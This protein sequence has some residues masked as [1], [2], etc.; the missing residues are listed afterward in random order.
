MSH[1]LDRA[2]SSP[3]CHSAIQGWYLSLWPVVHLWERWLKLRC[4]LC[5]S[6]TTLLGRDPHI[7]KKV[8]WY[9]FFPWAGAAE[10][11]T[12]LLYL[13]LWQTPTYLES[14]KVL[15]VSSHWVE[16]AGRERGTQGTHT[17][18]VSLK[19]FSGHQQL[20]PQSWRKVEQGAG[21]HLW[22][23]MT[24]GMGMFAFLLTLLPSWYRG[25]ERALLLGATW[26]NKQKP[27]SKNVEK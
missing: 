5:C 24:P 19:S 13:F 20:G 8:A 11:L 26:S 18:T 12:A 27:I 9:L 22:N 21:T 1:S 25:T 2:T 6:V 10:D 23:C 4:V 17:L 7:K 16:S 15:I 3:V 14:K